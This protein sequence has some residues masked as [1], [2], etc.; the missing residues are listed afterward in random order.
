MSPRSKAIIPTI[1]TAA[2][3]VDSN[4]SSYS[5]SD[6]EDS[7]DNTNSPFNANHDRQCSLDY[8][9][10][11][12][13]L[14][15]ESGEYSNG[16]FSEDSDDS[17]DSSEDLDNDTDSDSFVDSNST[18]NVSSSK[19]Y[20]SDFSTAWN[21]P[22]VIFTPYECKLFDDSSWCSNASK[23]YV[24]EL[25]QC[26]SHSNHSSDAEVSPN[27]LWPLQHVPFST[28][29]QN[30]ESYL[31]YNH[32]SKDYAGTNDY[33][34]TDDSDQED[35]LRLGA[36]NSTTY[37][38]SPHPNYFDV[39]SLIVSLQVLAEPVTTASISEAQNHENNSSENTITK[40]EDIISP[41]FPA[42]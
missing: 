28:N 5:N 4:P 7:N 13:D 20:S 14:S 3:L 37:A 36:S 31:I 10:D 2:P 27:I 8:S 39:N 25:N 9:D 16:D 15:D 11:G 19:D 23:D 18:S 21:L 26:V 1:S 33:P 17:N 12:G 32:N 41:F 29:S 35:F 42:E 40:I 34:S 6:D 30:H 22:E 24:L 38:L